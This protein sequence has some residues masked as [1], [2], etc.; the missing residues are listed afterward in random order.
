MGDLPTLGPL[1]SVAVLG[2]SVAF[3]DAYNTG[4]LPF[5]YHSVD[6]HPVMLQVEFEDGL[7]IS[8]LENRPLTPKSIQLK[9]EKFPKK[10]MCSKAAHP[11]FKSS[12]W[13]AYWCM[14]GFS[15]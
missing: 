13:C 1:E 11:L 8:V 4:I 3:T 10:S 2:F 12:T 7:S 6:I 9:I 15:R 5:Y 14:S